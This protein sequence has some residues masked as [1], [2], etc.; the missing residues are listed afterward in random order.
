[1]PEPTT[2]VDEGTNGHVEAITPKQLALMLKSNART[3][4]KF[5]RTQYG[6][7]GQG[8]RWGVEVDELRQFTEAWDQWRAKIDAR[9]KVQEA[10]TEEPE[11]AAEDEMEVDV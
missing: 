5:L 8:N 1:M 11:E 10:E 4:R 2:E 9:S 6:K 7:V 3:V